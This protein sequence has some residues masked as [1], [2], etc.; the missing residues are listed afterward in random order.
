MNDTLTIKLVQLSLH[1]VLPKYAN[2]GDAGL[3][4]LAAIDMEIVIP[5]GSRL[6]LPT[7]W[8]VEIPRGYEGQVRGRSS[9]NAKGVLVPLGTIDSAYRGE[10]SVVLLNLSGE[11]YWVHP[12]DRIAQLV[13]APVAC[14]VPMVVME[15]D[16]SERGA[17]GFG[18]TGR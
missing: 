14:V 4:L 3:D 5:N 12:G 13:I 15:L 18:S 8:A 7:G 2:P 16:P 1:A 11:P 17:G 9:L 10:I 6:R